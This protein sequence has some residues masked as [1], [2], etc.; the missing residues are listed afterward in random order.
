MQANTV[1]PHVSVDCAVLG[2]DGLQL[3]VLLLRRKGDDREGR[4]ND[5]KLPGSLVYA[6]E[7]LD[8]AAKRV[9][10]ELFSS[11][12]IYFRQFKCF[13]SPTR[14]SNPRDIE[15]LENAFKMK[16]GR[17]VTIGYLSLICMDEKLKLKSDMVEAFWCPVSEIRDLAFDHNKILE[18]AL[19]E[20]RRF[21]TVD[22]ALVF[23]LLPKKFTVVQ[24]RTLFEQI[25][26]QPMDVRNFN[27]KIEKMDYVVALDEHETGVAHRAARYYRF[28]K[29]KYSKS[30]GGF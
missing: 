14:T 30:L 18:A 12:T 25:F 10:G 24:M 5:L 15:W 1:N 23:T 6:D 27:K 7:D 16:I 26:D 17:I 9:L 2:F 4:F 11:D 19:L 21:V 3:N 22:P 8:E 28:D 13:G 29:K 20:V